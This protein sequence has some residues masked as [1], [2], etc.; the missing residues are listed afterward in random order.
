MFTK[1]KEIQTLYINVKKRYH[2]AACFGYMTCDGHNR[3]LSYVKLRRL[4]RT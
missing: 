1:T 4:Q 3:N 2:L